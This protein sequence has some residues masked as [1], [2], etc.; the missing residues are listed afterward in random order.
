MGDTGCGRCDRL[1]DVVRE[2]SD[3]KGDAQAS[4]LPAEA[5]RHACSN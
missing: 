4:P 3:L 1:V 5:R 2:L